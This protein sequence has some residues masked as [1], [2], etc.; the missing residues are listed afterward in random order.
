MELCHKKCVY[1]KFSDNTQKIFSYT[2]HL[3]PNLS[4]I[5]Q[6]LGILQFLLLHL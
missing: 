4:N 6:I 2:L 1:V 3:I 5:N